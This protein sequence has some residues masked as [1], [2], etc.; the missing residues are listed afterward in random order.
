MGPGDALIGLIGTLAIAT[1]G[2]AGPGEVMLTV[3]GATEAYLAFSPQPLP[4][5][6][7]VLV[8]GS[9]GNRSVDVSGWDD[10]LAS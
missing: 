9:R 6:A 3:Q 2:A 7:Q 4:R 1:R 8:I 5:G 10:P